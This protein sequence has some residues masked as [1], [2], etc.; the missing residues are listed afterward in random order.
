MRYRRVKR[1]S[2]TPADVLRRLRLNEK[3]QRDRLL[4]VG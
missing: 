3:W 2:G 4:S 1:D